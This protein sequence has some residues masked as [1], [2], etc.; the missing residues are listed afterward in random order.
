MSVTI[1]VERQIIVTATLR[2]EHVEQQ[3]FYRFI[4]AE[5]MQLLLGLAPEPFAITLSKIIGTSPSRAAMKYAA[6][7]AKVLNQILEVSG[8][9]QIN[10]ALEMVG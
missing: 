6:V 5:S 8:K 7:E 9:Q 4:K 3:D 2:E 1:P 10:V